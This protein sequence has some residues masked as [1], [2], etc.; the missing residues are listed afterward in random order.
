MVLI[1]HLSRYE[2]ARLTFDSG[3]YFNPYITVILIGRLDFF[4]IKNR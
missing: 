1:H 2:V 4:G 3:V